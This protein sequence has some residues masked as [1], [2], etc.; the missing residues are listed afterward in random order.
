MN[1]GQKMFHDF[2]LSLVQEGK[3]E[4]AEALLAES[5][6]KQS[7]GSFDA[8]YFLSVKDTY[9]TLIKPEHSEK[10]AEAMQSFSKRL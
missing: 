5:F 4:A 7:E 9:F 10:L 1:A 2:Y 6:A 3:E 8:A